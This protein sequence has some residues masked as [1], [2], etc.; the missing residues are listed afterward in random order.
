MNKLL[1]DFRSQ[2]LVHVLGG[3]H[4]SHKLPGKAL[5]VESWERRNWMAKVTGRSV[6]KQVKQVFTQLP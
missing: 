2:N 6:H 5:L 3:I 1:E 4:C